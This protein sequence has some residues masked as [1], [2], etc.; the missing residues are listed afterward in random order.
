MLSTQS[1]SPTTDVIDCFGTSVVALNSIIPTTDLIRCFGMRVVALNPIMLTYNGDVI[2][3]F[4]TSVV[5]HDQKGSLREGTDASP[6][7]FPPCVFFPLVNFPLAY[8]PPCI[9]F[10]VRFCVVQSFTR[11][12]TRYAPLHIA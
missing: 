4:E 11:D 6:N 2:R 8:F 7:E 3:C 5:S 1:C 9:Y 10:P 12:D